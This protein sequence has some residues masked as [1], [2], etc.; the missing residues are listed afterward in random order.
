M[1]VKIYHIN[2]LMDIF[3]IIVNYWQNYHLINHHVHFPSLQ[4]QNMLQIQ[5]YF[6]HLKMNP[7]NVILLVIQIPLPLITLTNV[8][9]K[10]VHLIVAILN[11]PII[12]HLHVVINYHIHLHMLIY[13]IVYDLLLV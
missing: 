13:Q 8:M 12:P 10:I 9:H 5:I 6:H 7:I 1:L 2:Q 11:V 4:L 3:V